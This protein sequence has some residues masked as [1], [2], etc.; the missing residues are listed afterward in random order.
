LEHQCVGNQP[1]LLVKISVLFK[2]ATQGWMHDLR[3][4]HCPINTPT[5]FRVKSR[6]LFRRVVNRSA[7][8]PQEIK[9]PTKSDDW[10]VI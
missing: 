4:H 1:A 7:K 10:S 3:Q 8:L 9:Y 5:L 6:I 2:P